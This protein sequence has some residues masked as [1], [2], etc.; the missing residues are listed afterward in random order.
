M[1]IEFTVRINAEETFSVSFSLAEV[2]ETQ[3]FVAREDEFAEIHRALSGDNSR[4]TVVLH[5]PVAYAKR[6]RDGYTGIRVEGRITSRLQY[7]AQFEFIS[8]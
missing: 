8:T 5:G 1:N 3:H 2:S 6:H 7:L 4:Q